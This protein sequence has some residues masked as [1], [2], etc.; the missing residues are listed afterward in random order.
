MANENYTRYGD[1]W[2]KEMEKLPK[3]VIIEMFSKIGYD[4]MEKKLYYE[5][6]NNVDVNITM[7]L[8]DCFEWIASDMEGLDENSNDVEY[9]IRP[10]WLTQDE[11]NNLPEASI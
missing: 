3:K 6:S 1:E 9:L 11:F 2:K 5:V 10:I 4:K 8:E 7:T